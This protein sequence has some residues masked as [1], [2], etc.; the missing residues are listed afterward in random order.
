MEENEDYKKRVTDLIDR[1]EKGEN[2]PE[3]YR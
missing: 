2:S 1:V 3:A